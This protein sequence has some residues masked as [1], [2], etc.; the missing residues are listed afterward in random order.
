VAVVDQRHQKW[1]L[2][3]PNNEQYKKNNSGFIFTSEIE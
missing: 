3:L 2:I 1:P